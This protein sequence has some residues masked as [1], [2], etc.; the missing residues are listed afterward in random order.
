MFPSMTHRFVLGA[1]MA[2]A[3]VGCG[4]GVWV[5]VGDDGDNPPDVSLVASADSA[6]AGQTVRLS[7]AA[8]DDWGVDYVAFYRLDDNGNAVL[9]GSDGVGPYQWDATMP[10]SSA[11]GVRFFARAV[12]GAGQAAESQTVVV[13][14]L[15]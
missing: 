6:A 2:L 7:A 9:L 1:A 3:L 13:T 14:L 12:D 15:H 4:G 10:N 8:S 11:A 5:G